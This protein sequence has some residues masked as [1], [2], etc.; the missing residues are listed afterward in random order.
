M[1]YR[2]SNSQKPEAMNFKGG[3]NLFCL[4][5]VWKLF[6][7]FSLSCFALQAEDKSS[8]KDPVSVQI[9]IKNWKKAARE[10]DQAEKNGRCKEAVCLALH[11][12]IAEGTGDGTQALAYANRAAALFGP[13]SG[14]KAGDYNDIGVILYHRGSH[15]PETLKLVEKALRQADAIYG[16]LAKPGASNIRFN[17]AIVL[18]AEG[19]TK[20]AKEIM[21]ALNA[22][23]MLIDPEMAILGDFQALGRR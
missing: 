6:P 4:S 1:D 19:R 5:A 22:R 7:I 3:L 10:L 8:V 11:A 2:S 12:R 9:Q 15:D 16:A 18:E 17:L 21:E 14:L 13:E 20:D 23:G